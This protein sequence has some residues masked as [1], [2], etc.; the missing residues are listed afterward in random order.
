MVDSIMGWIGSNGVAA[1]LI[2]LIAVLFL[3]L[4]K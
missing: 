3:V 2:V 4:R 1:V